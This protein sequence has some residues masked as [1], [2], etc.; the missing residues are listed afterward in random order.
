MERG[1]QIRKDFS[2]GTNP[3]DFVSLKYK[4]TKL[5]DLVILARQDQ[6][7]NNEL[8]NRLQP[9]IDRY[10]YN[11]IKENPF[12]EESDCYKKLTDIIE[13]TKRKYSSNIGSFIHFLRR[14]IKHFFSCFITSK[15]RN[16]IFLK[17]KVEV[18]QDLNEYVYKQSSLDEIKTDCD[19][20]YAFEE[21][22]KYF[23]KRFTD[24]FME[25]IS[26]MNKYE[27]CQ[28]YDISHYILNKKINDIQTFL[29][30]KMK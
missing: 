6:E 10:I 27:I 9:I 28:K 30:N 11:A 15:L 26:G 8:Y 12:L 3:H 20:M 17:D 14:N 24:I 25:Y 4:Y 23:G 22:N 2:T 13:Y 16:Y 18:K 5:D 29:Y 19:V 21:V 7:A 1:A